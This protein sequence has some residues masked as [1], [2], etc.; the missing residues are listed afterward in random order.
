MGLVNSGWLAFMARMAGRG[1]IPA[2]AL[3]KVAGV[4]PWARASIRICAIKASNLGSAELGGGGGKGAGWT[5]GDGGGGGTGL[6]AWVAQAARARR[7]ARTSR[8]VE[9]RF[10]MAMD[11]PV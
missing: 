4:M 9:R 6:G 8:R 1:A 3:S 10:A 11:T 7:A 5:G 2:V